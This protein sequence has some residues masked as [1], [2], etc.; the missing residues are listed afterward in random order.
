MFNKTI[1]SENFFIKGF[2]SK[3]LKID[4]FYLKNNVIKNYA[5]QEFRTKNKN[6]YKKNYLNLSYDKN[7]TWIHQYVEDFFKLRQ[8]QPIE[9]HTISGI[10]VLPNEYISLH[11]HINYYD[12]SDSPE[13]SFLYVLDCGK[14]PVE[15]EFTHESIFEKEKKSFVNLDKNEYLVFNSNLNHAITKNNN[16]TPNL[17][18]SMTFRFPRG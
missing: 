14:K 17:F 16:D 3:D 10:F 9:I 15:I 13:I 6:S 7:I 18:I 1:L 2:I 5:Y 4:Y 11:N 8:S 12:L